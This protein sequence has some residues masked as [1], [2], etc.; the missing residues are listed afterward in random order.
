[1]PS[2]LKRI[3]NFEQLPTDKLKKI[4][5]Q[6]LSEN[7]DHDL[8]EGTFYDGAMY[9]DFDGNRSEWHPAMADWCKNE[10]D[11]ENHK[12][13]KRNAEMQTMK[14]RYQEEEEATLV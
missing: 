3:E 11:Q 8:P 14:M 10:M 4:Q 13:A 7:P 12:V 9:I 5:D 2:A 1:M 6:A